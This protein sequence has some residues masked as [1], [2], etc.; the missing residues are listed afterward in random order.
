[1]CKRTC[2]SK[3]AFAFCEHLAE[4]GFLQVRRFS[5]FFLAM[6]VNTLVTFSAVGVQQIRTDLC[7][8]ETRVRKGHWKFMSKN[9]LKSLKFLKI[10]ILSKPNLKLLIKKSFPVLYF[11]DCLCG[12]FILLFVWGC[13]NSGNRR[14]ENKGIIFWKI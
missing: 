13:F 12:W 4:F 10:F 8:V 9:K 11:I 14:G 5:K 3:I 7:L 6:R 1:M 2:I